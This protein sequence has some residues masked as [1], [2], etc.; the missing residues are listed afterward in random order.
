VVCK[1]HG[2][3]VSPNISLQAKLVWRIGIF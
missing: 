3:T 1:K 2:L